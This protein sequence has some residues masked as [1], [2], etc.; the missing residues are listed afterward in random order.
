MIEVLPA[1]EQ[2]V[3][4]SAEVIEGGAAVA[5]LLKERD[6]TISAIR[7]AVEQLAD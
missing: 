5:V 3:I 2:P 4:E 7:I 1:G 6:G